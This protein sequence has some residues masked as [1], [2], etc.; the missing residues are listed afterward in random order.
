MQP[1]VPRQHVRASEGAV[2]KVAHVRQPAPA[3]RRPR[4]VPRGHVLSEPVRNSEDLKVNF[5]TQYLMQ[6][7]QKDR[8]F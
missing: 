7:N 5:T 1:H 4:L 3:V 2:A 8:T 6:K